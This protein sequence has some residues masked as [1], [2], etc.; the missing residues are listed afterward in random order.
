M[1]NL[2]SEILFFAPTGEWKK[3]DELECMFSRTMKRKV[4]IYY[5]YI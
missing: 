2:Y 3:N 4:Y 5:V 1:Y